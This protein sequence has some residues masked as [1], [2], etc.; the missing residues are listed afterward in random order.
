LTPGIKAIE[1]AGLVHKI[2]QY[3]HEPSAESWGEEAAD[4]LGVEPARV[5][6]TLV[7]TLDGQEMVVGLV[8]VNTR[9]NLKTLARE[10]GGKKAGM[11]QPKTVERGTGYVLGGVCPLGQKKSLR[12]FLDDSAS[13]FS[14]IYISAGRRGLEIEL[15]PDDLLALCGGHLAP[16]QHK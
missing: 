9:L 6:K 8:P 14:T 11:A 3:Q 2:H 7:V 16:L 15:A 10:A 13:Q 4:K 1:R 5:F 12:T